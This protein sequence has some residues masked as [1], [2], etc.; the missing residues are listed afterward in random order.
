MATFASN[1]NPVYDYFSRTIQLVIDKDDGRM[2]ISTQCKMCGELFVNVDETNA[3]ECLKHLHANHR[4]QYVTA[5]LGL[6][7]TSS[8]GSVYNCCADNDTI[9]NTQIAYAALKIERLF[10]KGKKHQAVEHLRETCEKIE[11]PHFFSCAHR[12]GIIV[13]KG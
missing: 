7:K 9:F 13:L 5:M 3:I 12:R 8:L 2:T 4:K 1:T 10:S 6:D 11:G